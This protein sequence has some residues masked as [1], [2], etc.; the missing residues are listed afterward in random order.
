M[1]LLTTVIITLPC[2]QSLRYGIQSLIQLSHHQRKLYP[3]LRIKHPE[4]IKS[5][6]TMEK[7]ECRTPTSAFY[8]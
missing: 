3:L 2:L 4:G 1:R 5:L 7:T 8:S 6:I